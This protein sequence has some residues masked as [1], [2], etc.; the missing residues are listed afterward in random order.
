MPLTNEDFLPRMDDWQNHEAKHTCGA[1]EIIPAC[2]GHWGSWRREIAIG[3]K[4]QEC[5]LQAAQ[6]MIARL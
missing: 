3:M 1:S 6:P 2:R 5:N 4:Y